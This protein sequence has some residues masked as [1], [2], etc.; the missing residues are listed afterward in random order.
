VCKA[1]TF[2][3]LAK[4][5]RGLFQKFNQKNM[6]K[7]LI[8]TI[9]IAAQSLAFAQKVS[10]VASNVHDGDTFWLNKP[11]G[12]V[13]KIRLASIDA[14]ELAQAYGKASRDFLKK[15][16]DQKTVVVDVQEKDKYQRS[17]GVVF[18]NNE[19]INRALVANGYAWHYLKYSR[20]AEL[21]KIEADAKMK[22]KGLWHDEKP[23]S[24]WQYRADKRAAQKIKMAA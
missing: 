16:I 17:V 8:L 9:L 14:P 18:L 13:L 12:T 7:I 3:D 23:L 20:D 6:K 4:N 22:K 1:P 21:S 15:L 2:A 10:G 11:D 19:N 5:R 24:P